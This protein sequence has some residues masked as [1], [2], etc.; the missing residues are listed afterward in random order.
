MKLFGRLNF[1]YLYIWFLE[2]L[3]GHNK[4]H[5][6]GQCHYVLYVCFLSTSFG[7][8]VVLALRSLSE[9]QESAQLLA[10]PMLPTVVLEPLLTNVENSGNLIGVVNFTPYDA[11]LERVCLRWKTTHDL[12]APDIRTFSIGSNSDAVAYSERV[13]GHELLQD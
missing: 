7:P 4:G 2:C 5:T 3:K 8:K 13:L 6:K 11:H 9:V 10:G 12:A 1:I